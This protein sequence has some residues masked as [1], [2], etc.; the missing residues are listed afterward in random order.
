MSTLGLQAVLLSAALLFAIGTAGVLVRRNT[1]FILLSIE[2]MLNASGLVFITAGSRWNQPDG[3]AA[4][5]F[6]L[7]IAAAEVCIGLAIVLEFYRKFSTIDVDAA[8][9]LKD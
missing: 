8:S 4:F 6:I 5:I 3:Q 2:L 1:I 9:T 7:A